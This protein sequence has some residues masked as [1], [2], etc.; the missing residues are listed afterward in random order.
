MKRWLPS[1]GSKKPPTTRT[2]LKEP[3]FIPNL[4]LLEDRILLA[5]T[6]SLTGGL[7]SVT[8][9]AA[10]DIVTLRLG[11]TNRIEV[12]SGAVVVSNFDPSAV[13][14]IVVNGGAGND[15]ITMSF[16][17]TVPVTLQGGAGNDT[18]AGGAGNEF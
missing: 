8:G 13:L 7:L 17:A 10:N 5:L 4:Q 14:R 1:L 18:L 11:T 6:S 16:A 9:D 2:R 12:L 15:S 3:R